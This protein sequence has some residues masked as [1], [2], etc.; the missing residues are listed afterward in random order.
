MF[1]RRLLSLVVALSA[2]G[3]LHAQEAT[4]DDALLEEVVVEGVRQAEL[5]ARQAERNKES[6]SSIIAQDDAGNFADQNVAESLQRLPGVTLQKSEGEG[7]KINLRG[8]GPQFVNVTINGSELASAGADDRGFGL[9]VISSDMLGGVVVNKTILPSMDTYSTAGSV[10]LK[11]ISAF[12]TNRD[13]LKLK[14]QLNQQNY[15]GELNPKLSLS[16]TNLL[17]DETV[18]IGYSVS[19]ETR[20]TVNYENLHHDD[21]K[22]RYFDPLNTGSPMLVPYESQVRQEDAERTRLSGS[23]DLGWRPTDNSEYTVRL[24]HTEYE[25]VDI[26]LREYYRFYSDREPYFSDPSNNSFAVGDAELQQ[27]FF[28]QESKVKTDAVAFEGMNRFADTWVVDYSLAYSSSTNDKPDGRRVQFRKQDMAMMGIYGDNFISGTPIRSGQL[29]ALTGDDYEV[30]DPDRDFKIYGADVLDFDGAYPSAYQ[31]LMAYDN[32][33]IEDS[34]REDTIG[35]FNLNLTKEFDEGIVKYV[36][37]GLQVKDRERTRDRN[38][39]SLKPSDFSDLCFDSDGTSTPEEIE[40]STKASTTNY[41]SDYISTYMPSHPEFNFEHITYGSAEALLTSTRAVADNFDPS[42]TDQSSRDED[43]SITEDSRAL[44]LEAKLEFSDTMSVITGVRYNQTDFESVGN[45]TIRNDRFESKNATESL[46]IVVPLEGTSKTYT[47]IHPSVHFIYEPSDEYMVRAAIWT[48]GTRPGFDQARAFARFDGRISV[49]NDDPTDTEFYEQCSDNP[50]NIGATDLDDI[51]N[52]FVV[53]SENTFGLGNPQLDP[54]YSVNF[55]TSVGWYPNEDLYLQA[56]VFYKDIKDFIVEVR[57]KSSSIE[58]LPVG[59]PTDEVP[60]FN[61]VPN[62][63]YSDVNFYDNGDSANVYGIE[64]SY[65][66]YFES[67]FFVQA[68]ATLLDSEAQMGDD[69]RAEAIKLPNMAAST[70]NLV[71]GWEN[72]FASARII[73]NYTSEILDK[74]GSCTAQDIADD[75]GGVPYNCETWNDVY[76]DAAFNLDF[77]ATYQATDDISLYL[78]LLNLTQEKTNRYMDGNSYSNGNIMYRHEDFG[79]SVQVGLNWK[80]Y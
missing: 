5:N 10:D 55:D 41:G 78:D 1:N 4:D 37:G 2:S 56:A 74:V 32:I 50:G 34:D 57:G 23:F 46:D 65:A 31:P 54:M 72:D 27:Q 28:I 36:K 17:A 70:L 30:S 64:L 16:G 33:F 61:F 13:S 3:A 43:Y 58:D 52:R 53:D 11:T 6:F 15:R 69:L 24:S 63:V 59:L 29:A 47:D 26:A 51:E 45:F 44:Y 38:R 40:C 75:A 25:D 73:G 22:A 12:D 48:S 19:A 68:N 21:E 39:V 18:G 79:T 77:K 76:Y 9:D 80:F 8:L 14:A 62:V 42:Q 71:L 20:K 7:Q 60:Y 67:D 66:Q 49:C 35:S